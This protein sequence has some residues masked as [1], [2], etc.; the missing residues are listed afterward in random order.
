MYISIYKKRKE[1]NGFGVTI[2]SC[3]CVV[4]TETVGYMQHASGADA[5]AYDAYI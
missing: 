5:L 3:R 2:A 4:S 1:G